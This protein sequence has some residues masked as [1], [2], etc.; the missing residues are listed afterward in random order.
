MSWSP[1]S[2]RKDLEANLR[3]IG[4]QDDGE[5][6]LAN[7][8]LWLAALDRPRVSLDRYQHHLTVLA[9]DTAQ[10]FEIS[11][12]E[13]DLSARIGAINS[14]IF[15][16]HAYQGDSLNYDDLQN[17]NLMRVIDRQKGLPI[18]LGILYI[19]CARA[20]GWSIQ[21][22]NFPGH[23]LLRM[24]AADDRRIIDPFHA[25]NQ[26]G[27]ADLRAMLKAIGGPE[28]ELRPEHYSPVSNRMILKRLQD[29]I[30]IRLLRAQQTG[31]ALEVVETMLMFAPSEANLWRDAGVLHAGQDNLRAAILSLE[32]YLLLCDSPDARHEAANLLQ[33]I[34]S[35]LN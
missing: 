2:G 13:D 10:E 20:Q 25:G 14:V 27:T 31:E 21:G 1:P 15:G 18:A 7:A 8:A 12:R 23:F 19:H 3:R 17:A 22:L 30:K 28:A 26:L 29:N 33:Q 11:G 32:Q 35:N 6:D 5:I 9:R 24:D 16:R 4:G 34:K